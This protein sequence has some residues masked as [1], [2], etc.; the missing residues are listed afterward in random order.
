MEVHALRP[1][2]ARADA[3]LPVIIIREASARPSQNWRPE[4]FE[5]FDDIGAKAIV[6]PETVIDARPQMLDEMAVDIGVDGGNGL[7]EEDVEAGGHELE[8]LLARA[9]WHLANCV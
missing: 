2:L 4:R 7:G 6:E 8:V 1:T 3:I 5:R 9:E